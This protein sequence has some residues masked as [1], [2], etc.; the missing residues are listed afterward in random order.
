MPLCP[1][2][3]SI[4]YP[5][6]LNSN[7]TGVYLLQE[8]RTDQCTHCALGLIW[9]IKGMVYQSSDQ[10]KIWFQNRRTKWKKVDIQRFFL[11]RWIWYKWL[12]S[13]L[14]GGENFEGGGNKNYALRAWKLFK[15]SKSMNTFA[16]WKKTYCNCKDISVELR[17]IQRVCVSHHLT[18]T[19]SD[20]RIAV[21]LISKQC[22]LWTLRLCATFAQH[23]FDNWSNWHNLQPQ[24]FIVF[25]FP[26]AQCNILAVGTKQ[27]ERHIDLFN[28]TEKKHLYCIQSSGFEMQ[29]ID[30]IKSREV[31]IFAL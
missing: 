1:P 30:F 11:L 21:S 9:E 23:V 14:K 2:E 26:S 4:I 25:S 5:F 15:S 3:G 19:G 20:S 29:Y 8:H 28:I 13:F 16:E 31:Y 17:P 27:H 10:V 6:I 18:E 24:N 22:K 12:M 7:A